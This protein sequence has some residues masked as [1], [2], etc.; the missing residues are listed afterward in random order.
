MS[1]EEIEAG[2]LKLPLTE[3]RRFLNWVFEHEDRLIGPNVDT[4]H[5]EVQAE[6]L[7]RREEALTDPGKL[8]TWESAFPRMKQQFDELRRKNP[9]AR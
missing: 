4:I 2:L 7:K 5:P 6:I 1:V 8:A 3:R 9:L